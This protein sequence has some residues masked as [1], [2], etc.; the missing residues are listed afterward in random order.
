MERGHA[1]G[2]C[3]WSIGVRGSEG[4]KRSSSEG[5]IGGKW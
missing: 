3:E 5:G 4:G 1:H 2:G